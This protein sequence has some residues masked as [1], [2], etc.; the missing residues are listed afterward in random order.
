MHAGACC[1]DKQNWGN[2]ET[3]G[4]IGGDR[5]HNPVLPADYSDIDVIR[6]ELDYYAISSTF[7]YSPGMAILHSRDLV[8]WKLIGHAIEDVTQIGPEFGWRQMNG[9]GRGVWAGAIRYHGGRFWIYFG[10]PDEGF[11]VTTAKNPHGPWEPLQ[12]VLKEAGWDDCCPFWDDD[13][14]GYLVGT[15]FAD[16]YKTWLFTLSSD[17]YSI[18][19]TQVL[20]AEGSGREASKIYK[21][22]AIYYHL[23]SEHIPG[24]GRHLMMQRAKSIEGPYLEAHQLSYPQTEANEPNQGGLVQTPNGSWVFLTHHGTGDWEGRCISLLPV[25][26]IDGWPKIGQPD[27]SGVGTMV[28]S[29][30]KPESVDGE[31]FEPPGSDDFRGHEL[32]PQWEWNHQPRSS[33]WS[34]T[35]KPC[36]LRLYAFQPVERDDLKTVG[37]VLTQRALRTNY[38]TVTLELQLD[39][40]AEGQVAGLCHFS[41]TYS[42][43]GVRLE[44][45]CVYLEARHNSVVS[46]GLYL[47]TK[48][49]WLR[50]SWGLDGVSSFSY[51]TGERQFTPFPPESSY[52]LRWGDYRGDRIGIF[53]LNNDLDAGYVDCESFTYAT[54]KVDDKHNQDSTPDVHLDLRDMLVPSQEEQ[55][56]NPLIPDMLADPSI[57]EFDGVCY[58][59]ATTDGWGQGFAASGTAVVWTSKDFC[60]WNFEGSCF[61]RD[62]DLKYW[63]PSAVIFH[64]GRYYMFP[65]LD[66]KIAVA[67]ADSPLGPFRSPDGQ[68]ITRETFKPYPLQQA[69]AIDAEVFVDDDGTSYMVFSRRRI[70]KLKPDLLALD[71]PVTTIPTKREGYSEGPWLMKRKDVYY[72]LYTIGGAE[73]YQYA[74]MTS[75][76]SPLGPWEAPENDIIARTSVKTGVFGPGHGCVFNLR[77]TDDWYFVFL[78]F[79]RGGTN[80]SVFTSKMHFESDGSIRTINLTK[81]GVGKLRHFKEDNALREISLHACA[82]TASS[83]RPDVAIPSEG[84]PTLFRMERSTAS[85]AVNHLN[86]TRWLAD[87]SDPS[88]WFSLDLGKPCDVQVLELFFVKPAAGHAFQFDV[89]LDGQDWLRIGDCGSFAMRSPHRVKNLVHVRYVKITILQG[90]PGLWRVRAFL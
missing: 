57:V 89:S 51:S 7:Q 10:T 52:Q 1:A 9:Y 34:L 21:I 14:R 75:V 18:A 73:M 20:L 83:S 72:Y 35:E 88:P 39:G 81:N 66:E 30:E 23:Y 79:G 71:G 68:N 22:G 69:C 42:S 78:E 55:F 11:F 90:E 44:K 61:P 17:G 67:V 60:N 77:G 41:S 49:I 86:G 63:A 27:A 28:W 76:T 82:V 85:L 47:H 74:Y 59:Y 46:L 84:D 26:W 62:F 32:G 31:G 54:S 40:L 13:G 58:C 65:T 87:P 36:A 29:G 6:V 64:E 48:R 70:A 12:C 53:T 5:Y 24:Q 37:N 2:W 38:N 16:G 50:S 4:D 25:T 80:R 19:K 3:W 56:G 33:H 45:G 15:N 43:I 8:S